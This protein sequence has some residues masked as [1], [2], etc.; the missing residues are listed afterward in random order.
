MTQKERLLKMGS[1]FRHF[2]FFCRRF[3]IFF[4][5]KLNK[6]FI[7]KHNSIDLKIKIKV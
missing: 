5:K 1:F 2:S 7:L 4:L 6:V 3:E